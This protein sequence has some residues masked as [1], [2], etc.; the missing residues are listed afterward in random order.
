MPSRNT[1]AIGHL[2]ILGTGYISPFH[3]PLSP[4]FAPYRSLDIHTN[5]PVQDIYDRK[6]FPQQIPA[7]KLT[8]VLYSFADNQPDGTVYLT[9]PYADTDIH[10]DGDSWDVPAGQKNV[11][12]VIKQL[13]LLKRANRNLKVLLSIGGWSYTNEKKHLDSPA[14]TA[15]GRARFAASCV[16][17]IKDCGFDGIDV[18]WEYPQDAAQ[19][20]QMVELLREVR[21]QMDGYAGT[22]VYGD[23]EGREMRPRFLL[24]IA[25]PAGAENY[26]KMLLRDVAGVVDFVNLMV[27]GSWSSWGLERGML[28][29]AGV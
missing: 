26:R 13:S 18:D 21:R 29:H 27:S 1:V 10:F 8:H 24:S 6:F 11:Y 19:A 28:I 3:S 14:A 7:G 22:L 4:L 9:D 12:G 15:A 23:K 5:T 20:Q 16:Q 17:L 25:A 2:L